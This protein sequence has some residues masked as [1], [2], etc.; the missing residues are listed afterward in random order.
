MKFIC[1]VCGGRIDPHIVPDGISF[2]CTNYAECGA[3]I[4]FE[5][6][7]YEEQP[8]LALERFSKRF[9]VDRERRTNDEV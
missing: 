1:P 8:Q 4:T 6:S 9:R 5:G 2:F 7:P 3:V